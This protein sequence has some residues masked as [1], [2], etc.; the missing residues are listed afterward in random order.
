MDDLYLLAELDTPDGLQAYWT[1]DG[2]V[3]ALAALTGSAVTFVALAVLDIAPIPQRGGI[4]IPRATVSLCVDT[5]QPAFAT[6]RDQ[7]SPFAVWARVI[8]GRPAA[9]GTVTVI[10]QFYGR[11]TRR[12]LVEGRFTLQVEHIAATWLEDQG[13]PEVLSDE[14]HQLDFP[15]DEGFRLLA[16]AHQRLSH[17]NWPAK[18]EGG[19]G[20]RF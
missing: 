18:D 14:R 15:G 2:D 19:S 13:D 6:L 8:N 1:G 5:E 17:T 20:I 16:V 10:D 7:T 4:S 12:E 3:S 11:S 9:D